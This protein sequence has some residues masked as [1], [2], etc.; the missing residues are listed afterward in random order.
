MSADLL[1]LCAGFVV[2]YLYFGILHW[3]ISENQRNAWFILLYPYEYYLEWK[4]R[5]EAVREVSI[6]R[7]PWERSTDE[8]KAARVKSSER[9]R[10]RR[11]Q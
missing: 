5:R 11:I 3:I 6:I 8:L 7:H 1:K 10:D 2:G 4:Q 9:D